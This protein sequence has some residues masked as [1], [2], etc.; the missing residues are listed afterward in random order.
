MCGSVSIRLPEAF[1]LI[2]GQ[3]PVCYH[4]ANYSDREIVGLNVLNAGRKATDFAV[5]HHGGRSSTGRAL[6]C[7]TSGCGFNSRRPPH[8]HYL[9]NGFCSMSKIGQDIA[10]VY[11]EMLDPQN[12]EYFGDARLGRFNATLRTAGVD[13]SLQSAGVETSKTMLSEGYDFVDSVL[14][15]SRRGRVMN[16]CVRGAKEIYCSRG[17]STEWACMEQVVRYV[18]NRAYDESFREVWDQGLFKPD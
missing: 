3:S 1:L 18:F 8:V 9:F 12:Q 15:E 13:L 2:P 4:P 7:G 11:A 17:S 6:V 16:V 14:S 10:A 5:L